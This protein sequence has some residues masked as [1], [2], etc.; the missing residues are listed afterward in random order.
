MKDVSRRYAIAALGFVFLAVAGGP[1]R[2]APSVVGTYANGN[3][4]ATLELKSG[5][6]ASF[7]VMGDMK[8]CTY[9]QEAAKLTVTCKDQEKFDFSVHDDGSITSVGTFIGNMKKS[10]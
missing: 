7:A 5:G 1:A 3:G 4:L 2:G 8:A 6:K 9:K 10:K